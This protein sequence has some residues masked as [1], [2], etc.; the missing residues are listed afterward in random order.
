MLISQKQTIA[1]YLIKIKYLLDTK[2][3]HLAKHQFF[4]IVLFKQKKNV[5]LSMIFICIANIKVMNDF[6]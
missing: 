4:M 5:F 1:F 2:D 6:I 3:H